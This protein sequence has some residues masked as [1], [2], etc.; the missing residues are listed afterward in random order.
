MSSLCTASLSD[1]SNPYQGSWTPKA[2][3][4]GRKLVRL[5]C[6]LLSGKDVWSDIPLLL[7]TQTV[8]SLLKYYESPVFLTLSR[9]VSRGERKYSL[10]TTFSMYRHSNT[11][12][13]FFKLFSSVFF[14]FFPRVFVYVSRELKNKSIFIVSCVCFHGV[15][16]MQICYFQK[17][18]QGSWTLPALPFLWLLCIPALSTTP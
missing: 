8:L 7:M 4:I 5:N 9:D 16:Q 2:V 18:E 15:V 1:M 17:P 13:L 11:K 12:L 3:L 6:H 10:L 14:F